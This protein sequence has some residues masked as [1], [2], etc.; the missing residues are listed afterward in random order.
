MWNRTRPV[1]RHGNSMKETQPRAADLLFSGGRVITMEDPVEAREM[2]L[3]VAGGKIL[4]IGATGELGPFMGPQTRVIETGGKTL[5]PGFIDSHN[6]M[7][8]F[9]Q[10]MQAVDLR[11]PRIKNLDQIVMELQKAA[12]RAPR[13]TWIKAWG[14]DDTLLEEKRHPTREELDR[15]CPDHPVSLVRICAHVMA[16]NSLA[17]RI[18]GITD[19]TADP[20]GGKIGRDPRGRPNGLLFEMDALN[21]VNRL[22]PLPT[23]SECALAL[24]AASRIYVREGITLATEA[25]AGFSGNANEAAGFQIALQSGFLKPRIVMGL[26]EK[27]YKI[28]PGDNGVGLFTGFGDDFLRLGPLKFVADGGIGARMAAVT[29]P[30]EG[31]DSLGFLSED[32]E[33]L[34]GRME[35]AHVLGF[36]IS[37]HA[38]GD[39]ALDL[40]LSNYEEILRRHPR[41]HRH[42]IEHAMVCRPDLIERL[43]R[44]GIIVVTQPGLLWSLGDS[45]LENL[46]PRRHREILPLKSMIQGGVIVA[47]S[48]DRPVAEG[49]PWLGIWAAVNRLTLGGEEINPEE[50]LDIVQ[51]LKLYTR[52]GAFV[53][54][55]EDRTGTLSAG[56]AADLIVMDENPLEV[57]PSRLKDIT[58][59]MTFI[60]GREVY[61]Q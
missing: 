13:G 5:M 50:R 14:Y 31:S 26:M 29:Q 45:Y 24:E 25:G 47:G 44:S 12:V 55:V 49:N 19:K 46:G 41:P 3:A 61:R 23:P 22:I 35:A 38:T 59:K 18:A 20:E 51:A 34:A 54:Y 8:Y 30:Y 11:P 10:N 33:S 17:L 9:G 21:L 1:S 28:F 40:V 58:V 4:S 37:I 27:T 36:Q 53:N 15:A 57:A 43:H 52:N 2:D 42:R 39:R 56:K 60:N 7:L 16:V 48:S 6:H 32:P